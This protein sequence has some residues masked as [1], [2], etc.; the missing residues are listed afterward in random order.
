[1]EAVIFDWDGTLVDSLGPLYRANLAVMRSFGLAYDE[2][3]YR[4]TYQ[5]DWRRMY[6]RLGIPA[7]RIDEANELW[8]AAYDGGSANA[9]FP[10]RSAGT[11]VTRAFALSSSTYRSFVIEW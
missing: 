7:E 10:G 4:S 11:S 6:G 3:T 9:L 5:P 1:M 8:H 2:A